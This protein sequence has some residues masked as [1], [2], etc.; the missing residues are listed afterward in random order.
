MGGRAEGS[1][2]G[3]RPNQR[4]SPG[5]VG[6][7]GSGVL[8]EAC[9]LQ[10]GRLLHNTQE[11]QGPPPLE[12]TVILSASSC[13]GVHPTD[14]QTPPARFYTAPRGWHPFPH[15]FC[16][17]PPS[18]ASRNTCGGNSRLLRFPT[19]CCAL[20]APG[21]PAPWAPAG[22]LC[23]WGTDAVPHLCYLGH[24]LPNDTHKMGSDTQPCIWAAPR[25]SGVLG[26][27]NRP[28]LIGQGWGRASQP[29]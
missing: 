4:P 19:H 23:R 26:G 9:S 21:T 12:G 5:R 18:P 20:G 7:R 13:K 10:P 17:A 2:Q 11:V 25:E 22:R 3:L 14:V 1:R 27:P 28:G 6:G 29:L 16:P 8:W 15:L 24:S